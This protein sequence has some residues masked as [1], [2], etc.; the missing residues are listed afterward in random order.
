LGILGTIK[1]KKFR[2][3]LLKIWLGKAPAQESLKEEMLGK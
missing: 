2:V 3:A 1:G